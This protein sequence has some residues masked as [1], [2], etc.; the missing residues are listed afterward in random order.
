MKSCASLPSPE[1]IHLWL[2]S[3]VS[4][5][6]SDDLVT[7]LSPEERERASSYLF[8]HDRRRFVGATALLR[9]IL[10]HYLAKPARTLTFCRGD[11]GKPALAGPEAATLSFNLSR[12]HDTAFLAVGGGPELG[13]DIECQRELPDLDLLVRRQYSKPEQ[14]HLLRSDDREHSFFRIWARKEAYIKARGHGL[15]HPLREFSTV[16]S[17]REEEGLHLVDDWSAEASHA[18][19]WVRD[20]DLPVTGY[21]AAVAHGSAVKVGLPTVIPAESLASFAADLG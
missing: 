11:W 8:A 14:D 4:A 10:A 7:H 17:G 19:W 9:L 6:S 13:A 3:G 20:V 12:S 2:C 21:A 15:S 16:S 5:A 18:E 1:E